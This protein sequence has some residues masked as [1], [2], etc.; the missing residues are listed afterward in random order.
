MFRNTNGLLHRLYVQWL[1]F[2]CFKRSAAP[3]VLWLNDVVTFTVSIVQLWNSTWCWY[4]RFLS[5]CP[6]NLMTTTMRGKAALSGTELF[7]SRC[8]SQVCFHT[9]CSCVCYVSQPNSL[10]WDGPS[11][12]HWIWFKALTEASG[13]EARG[14]W[15]W[16]RREW[17]EF[18]LRAG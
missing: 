9:L 18:C 15:E 17:F 4:W 14:A 11:M 16:T 7:T 2:F 13:F 5:P 8:V 10:P 6:F 12:A 3:A 1:F